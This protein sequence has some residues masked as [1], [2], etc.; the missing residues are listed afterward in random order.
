MRYSK[1]YNFIADLTETA[2]GVTS[3]PE[4]HDFF[5]KPNSARTGNITRS[6]SA[7]VSYL[8]KVLLGALY[9]TPTSKNYYSI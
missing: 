7:F 4:G 3:S 2:D 5:Y 9:L 8:K 1:N 6:I